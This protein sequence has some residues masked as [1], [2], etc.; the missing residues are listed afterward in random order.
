MSD[1]WKKGAVIFSCSSLFIFLSYLSR[2]CQ[3][4][5]YNEFPLRTS[6]KRF[7][8]SM[9]CS[10]SCVSSLWNH[11]RKWVTISRGIPITIFNPQESCNLPFQ[12]VENTPLL[13]LR[14]E[15][16]LTNFLAKSRLYY[17]APQYI[18]SVLLIYW[19]YGVLVSARQPR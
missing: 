9:H 8:S 18:P 3:Q 6:S 14:F 15:T 17:T 7:F 4:H 12:Q 2:A 16:A 11:C 5:E 13:S 19:M 10:G 1:L